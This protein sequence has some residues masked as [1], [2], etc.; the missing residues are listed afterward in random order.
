M[1]NCR[2]NTKE[3]ILNEV[4]NGDFVEE[5]N[6]TVHIS[7]LRKLLGATESQPIIGTVTGRGYQFVAKVHP[8]ANNDAVDEIFEDS[9]ISNPNP[10]MASKPDSIAV[11]PLKNENGDEEI[12]Y[13][14]DGITESLINSLSYMP[15]FR[16]LARDTVFRYKD[17]D[18]N[19]QE[20]GD[21][22]GVSTVLTGR[23][24]VIRDHLI[25]GVELVNVKDGTQIW[26][27]QINQP[28]TDIFKVQESLTKAIVKRFLFEPSKYINETNIG[29]STNSHESYRLYLKGKYLLNKKT[30]AD[31]QLA[32]NYFREA[33]SIDPTNALSFVG[34]GECYYWLHSL[35]YLSH[36][37]VLPLIETTLSE[38]IKLN[39]YSPELYT[40]KG[41]LERDLK[42]KFEKS[43]TF[44]LKALALK[45]NHF[46]ALRSYSQVLAQ[47]G[48][49]TESLSVVK[50]LKK[51]SPISPNTNITAGRLFYNCAKYE[52]AIME[53]NEAIELDPNNHIAMVLLGCTHI[54]IGETKTAEE[55]FHKAS[56]IQHHEE[57]DV[58]IAYAKAR[59]GNRPEAMKILHDLEKRSRNVYIPQIHFAKIYSGLGEIDK[60]FAHLKL[61]FTDRN[62]ALTSL[63]INPRFANLRNDPRF[64]DLLS[65][66]G[67]P[68]D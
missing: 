15:D 22:L 60:A 36:S 25:I 28:F 43:K 7:K 44:Y 62:E 31:L 23:L 34:M 39:S 40:L 32:I 51:L 27:T 37:E 66:I 38:A 68:T 17:K 16:V 35:V 10:P 49:F 42:W 24:R 59:A 30:H 64:N 54:E 13:L 8:E 11:L 4:W 63:K 20:I 52:S 57:F 19:A 53:L 46:E 55:F 6:L 29:R 61:A 41:D 58:L 50:T 56:E 9:N 12:D 18:V 2:V 1:F 5:G 67:L 33:S 48:K 45:P 14:A 21:E 65:R 26:G 47:E 3:E